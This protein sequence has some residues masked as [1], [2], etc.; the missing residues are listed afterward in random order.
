MRNNSKFKIG[1]LAGPRP[2]WLVTVLVSVL[3]LFVG[4]V[5]PE[6]TASSKGRSAKE[7]ESS[8]L[9]REDKIVEKIQNESVKELI[10][11]LSSELPEIRLA[12]AS[13]LSRRSF[14]A[15]EAVPALSK[16]AREDKDEQIRERAAEALRN[17]RGYD[18]LRLP[19]PKKSTP[20]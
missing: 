17:I 13:E 16:L 5:V 2:V 14:S 11:E 12:A 19:V 1:V 8:E 18:V 15:S 4:C 9:S 10:V 6:K 7:G 20:N 3:M